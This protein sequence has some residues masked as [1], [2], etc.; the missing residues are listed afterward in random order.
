MARALA[1]GDA[2]AARYHLLEWPEARAARYVAHWSRQHG[3][4]SALINFIC[5]CCG[6]GFYSEPD[7]HTVNGAPLCEGCADSHYVYSEVQEGYI[8]ESDAY[9]IYYHLD[10]L[11]SEEPE[12]YC[13]RRYHTSLGSGL[14]IVPYYDDGP[15]RLSF[16]VF[17]VFEEWCESHEA[18]DR[19]DESNSLIR[20]YHSGY[21]VGLIKSTKYL[22]ARP[23]ALVGIELEIECGSRSAEDVAWS[24]ESVANNKS[25]VC[26]FEYDGSLM[27]G[28]EVITG[29]TGLDRMRE[30]VKSIL[31]ADLSRCK[32]HD[33]NTCGLHVHIDRSG[34]SPLETAKLI[35][36]INS[37][38]NEAL[39]RAV[40][41]RYGVDMA[42]LDAQKEKNAF[43]DVKRALGSGH[44]INFSR[45]N[46]SRYEFLNFS[47]LRTIEFRGYRGTLRY[48]TAMACIEFTYMA[49]AFVRSGV[50]VSRLDTS[51]FLEFVQQ[52][53]YSYES[54][55][56]RALLIERGLLPQSKKARMARAEQVSLF[57][58]ETIN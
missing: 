31:S 3:D 13:T 26:K 34:I 28:V 16:A 4:A 49:L 40:A 12:D 14:H 38:R 19:D 48:L 8:N 29:Y 23:R 6:T 21:E 45:L 11:V 24:I 56:L 1:D 39:I 58:N 41:R 9:P 7:Y 22:D 43:V 25:E 57:E 5:N 17:D 55:H 2:D 47:N 30:I 46:N 33:T 27:N 50:S 42:K 15:S 44:W 35:V 18:E 32:S 37:A 20:P 53:R 54:Q 51:T 10:R 52:P 36:F